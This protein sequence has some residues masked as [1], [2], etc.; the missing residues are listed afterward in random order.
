M[1]TGT[2]PF[3]ADDPMTI[4]KR[5]INEQPR[6]PSQVAPDARIPPRLELAVLRALAKQS[7]DRYLSAREFLT[8]LEVDELKTSQNPV[9]A[10]A[11]AALRVELAARSER[12]R[13]D[14]LIW[15]GAGGLG[16]VLLLAVV[17]SW[18]DGGGD[19]PLFPGQSAIAAEG[20][21]SAGVLAEAERLV[22]QAGE[23]ETVDLRQSAADRLVALGF[24]DRVPV[25]QKLSRDLHQLATCEDRL[26]VLEKLEKL[27]DP[28]SLP[29]LRAAVA[30]PD[31][32]C[33]E[34]RARALIEKLEK[35]TAAR[36]PT[37][38]KSGEPTPAKKA[39]PAGRTPTPKTDASGKKSGGGGHF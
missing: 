19:V 15:G 4:V 21:P 12:R 16:I 37:P 9:V 32:D 20:G 2:R 18:G 29:S 17:L 5:A 8:L 13:R 34:A 22:K 7:H 38:G 30:R 24:G 25:A 10:A 28:A 1:L 11:T 31:N 35:N 36:T 23:G 6:P 26:G 27:K 3:T 14:Y 33:L 39:P